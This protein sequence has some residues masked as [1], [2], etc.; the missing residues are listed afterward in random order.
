MVCIYIGRHFGLTF[1]PNSWYRNIKGH[2]FRA[3]LANKSNSHSLLELHAL[4][5]YGEFEVLYCVSILW[6][7]ADSDALQ[8]VAWVPIS[9]EITFLFIGTKKL[10]NFETNL[11][12]Y[13]DPHLHNPIKTVQGQWKVILGWTLKGI[14]L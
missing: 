12:L 14:V 5:G 11:N 3:E 8:K 4:S 2:A 6:S 9:P 10:D 1:N 7:K 13:L